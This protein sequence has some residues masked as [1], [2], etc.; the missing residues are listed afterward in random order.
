M[1]KKAARHLNK[2]EIAT[3]FMKKRSK[4][5]QNEGYKYALN[6]SNAFLL[7][8]IFA[9]ALDTCIML[10]PITFWELFM[11]LILAGIL[12]VFF[13][14][15]LELVMFVCIAISI[16]TFNPLLIAKSGGQTLGK[17][18]YDL[19]VV[20]KN[21]KEASTAI[22]MAREVIGFSLPTFVLFF[23]FNIFGVIA[24][25][26]LDFLFLLVHP[27]HISIIDLFLGTRVVVLRKPSVKQ[28][29][30]PA[31]EEP[32][33]IV[34]TIDLHVHSNFSDD[35]VYNVEELF[36][37]AA[38]QGLKTISICDHNSAKANMI[39]ERMSE[40]YHVDYVPGIE[41][42]CRYGNA[43]LRVLGYFINWSSDIYAHL[44]NESLKREKNASLKR[45]E[46]FEQFAGIKV[47]VESLLHKNRFQKITGTMIAKQVL[48]EPAFHEHPL[49]APYL[50][51]DRKTS[52][53]QAMSEDFFGKDGPCYVEVRHPKLEDILDIIHLTGGVAVLSWAKDT[54][55]LG[56]E[57]FEEILAKGIEGIEVFTPYYSSKDM[58][59]LLKQAKDHHLFVTAG[60]DF[61]GGFRTDIQI[62]ET[63]APIEAEKFVTNFLSV[64]QNR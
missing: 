55:E 51:G 35:G 15:P 21:H 62:G 47:D 40:L 7:E 23:F 39:A 52:P 13:L 44:E 31:K 3:V 41:L 9:F 27:K 64:Y 48:Q 42:D 30:E 36:Q 19:K 37:M 43:H 54:Y 20:Q 59:I 46:L 16:F 18:F 6:I 57:T 58:A 12:P 24:Y 22:L 2:K 28:E 32:E 25:W 10:L 49:L 53:Y 14:T 5:Y 26:A 29:L 17:Y 4:Q 63:H 56:I 8:R 61:H 11:L 33:T 34:N 38:R 60:S 50:Y 45:V 1:E